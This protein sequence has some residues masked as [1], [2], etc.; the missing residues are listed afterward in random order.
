MMRVRPRGGLLV[1][2]E[3]SLRRMVLV[4]SESVLRLRKRKSWNTLENAT[5]LD[6]QVHVQ[7]LA[8][9]VLLV[10][11]LDASFFNQVNSLQTQS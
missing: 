2:E 8:P 7:V 6:E 11:V 9:G 1:L 5:Y 3:M 4:K 10:L